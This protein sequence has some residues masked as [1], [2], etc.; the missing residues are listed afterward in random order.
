MKYV[1]EGARGFFAGVMEYFRHQMM[2][3]KMFL[4]I[5]DGQNKKIHVK[6]NVKSTQIYGKW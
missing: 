1:G 3:H 2:S 5:F 6:Q 4:K